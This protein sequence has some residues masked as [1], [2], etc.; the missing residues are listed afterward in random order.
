MKNNGFERVAQAVRK[1]EART[2]GEFVVCVVRR[3]SGVAQASAIAALV[4]FSTLLMISNLTADFGNY[5]HPLAGWFFEAGLAVLLGHFAGRNETVQ[6]LFLPKHERQLLVQRRARLEFHQNH[7]EKTKGATGVLIFVS[8]MERQAVVL[9]DRSIASRLA[10]EAW[11]SVLKKILTGVKQGD[12]SAGLVQALELSA[13]LVA[14]HFPR[15]GKNK[16]ELSDR[17]IIKE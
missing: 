2:T 12:L 6:R 7:L 13:D 11:E 10:P 17:L 3:S 14:P 15:K 16:N 4:I 1:A 8:L 5:S 9:A